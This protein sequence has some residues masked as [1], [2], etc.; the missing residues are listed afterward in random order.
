MRKVYQCFRCGKWFEHPSRQ[1]EEGFG[2]LEFCPQCG[3]RVYPVRGAKRVLVCLG[4]WVWDALKC[5]KRI[6][7]RPNEE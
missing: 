5:S 1:H 4:W 6:S 2:T 3:M 7:D